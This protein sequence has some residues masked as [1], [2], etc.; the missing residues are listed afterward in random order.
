[1]HN[2]LDLFC[3]AGGL[4]LGFARS[5]SYNIVAAAEINVNAQ[6]TFLHNHNINRENMYND[7][8]AIDYTNLKEKVGK[9]DVVI[10]G[11]P[12][13]GFSNANRQKNHMISLNNKLVKQYIRAIKELEPKAFVMEN[14]SMLKSDVHRFYVETTDEEEIKKF[15]IPLRD[16]NMLLLES[17]YMFENAINIAQNASSINDNIWDESIYY[18]INVVYKRN[19]N[20]DKLKKFLKN[21][22]RK[23]W[24]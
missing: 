7:V 12:C 10:G 8:A 23:F 13:Q 1:M 15:N 11:P 24:H 22:K 19:K 5:G 9:I 14:V 21:T 18:L 3:G 16:E 2:V 20:T 6:Q 4:S 17:Q